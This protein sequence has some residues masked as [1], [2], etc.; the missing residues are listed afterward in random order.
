VADRFFYLAMLGPA[1]GVAWLLAAAPWR[2]AVPIAIGAGVVLAIL[3]TVQLSVWADTGTLAGQALKMDAGSAIGNYIAGEE[4][5]VAG[6]PQ[7]AEACFRRAIER[8]PGYPEVH[9]DLG[10]VYLLEQKYELAAH[11]FEEAI[12]RWQSPSIRAMNNLG[13]AYARM[14]RMGDAEGEFRKILEIDPNNAAAKRNLK[15]ILDGVPTR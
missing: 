9:Y 3:T 8:D 15:I 1:L 5:S 14:G 7:K 2:A 4:A 12:R 6:N 10:N 13:Y 11:E